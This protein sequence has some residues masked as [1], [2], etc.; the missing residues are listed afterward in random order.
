MLNMISKIFYGKIKTTH[1]AH[2][3]Y[4]QHVGINYRNIETGRIGQR[5]I[6]VISFKIICIAPQRE[7]DRSEVG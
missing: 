2:Y 3:S 6:Q 7:V 1:N 5:E 4:V